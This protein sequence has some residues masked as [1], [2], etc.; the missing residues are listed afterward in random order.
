MVRKG[1]SFSGRERNCCFLNLGDGK[2]ADVSAVSGFDFPDDGRAVAMCDWDF[3]GDLDLWVA[4]RS[5]PQLRFLQNNLE[6]PHHFLSIRLEGKSS[7][8]DAIGARVEVVFKN[9]SSGSNDLKLVRTLRAGEGFLAQSSKWLHFGLGATEE[10]EKVVVRWPGGKVEEFASIEVDN[11]YRLVEHSGKAK[12]WTPPQRSNSLEPEALSEPKSTDHARVVFATQLPMPPL[13]YETFDGKQHRLED[14]TSGR[15]MLVNLW[16]SWCQPCLRELRELAD[17][18]IELREA[19]VTILAL[20]VDRL[21]NEKGSTQAAAA[22]LLTNV[23]YSGKAGWASA[24]SVEKLQLVLNHLFDLHQPIQVPTSLLIN[25][26]GQL[27]A[28]YRGPV[29][30]DQLLADVG[31]LPNLSSSPTALPFA[32]RWHTRSRRLSPLDVAWQLVEHGY[33][34]ESIEYVT[35]NRKLLENSYNI[36]KLLVLIGNGQLARGEA[37]SAISFYRDALKIDVSYGEA[38]NNLAWVLATHPD[39]S[40]RNGKEAI[41]LTIEALQQGSGNATSMLDTLAAAYAENE[42]FDRAIKV[43]Q[44]AIEIATANGQLESAKSIGSRLELYKTEQPFRDE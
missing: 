24:A 41:R 29:S 2:F 14:A 11:H 27:A 28:L 4:N 33:L 19:G 10:I 43:A 7:N 17:R 1:K 3:D 16:A 23:G 20:S 12:P 40:M 13:G 34:D 18:K 25:S 26:K 5:G 30:V 35:K 6:T 38:K 9:P 37:R 31:Q 36:P 44:K 32:G 8:R 21:D 22:K 39:A 15:P 42:Q